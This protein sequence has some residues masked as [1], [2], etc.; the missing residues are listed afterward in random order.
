MTKGLGAQ[1]APFLEHTLSQPSASQAFDFLGGS[2]L[3]E[4]HAALEEGMPGES[5]CCWG[6]PRILKEA[7]VTTHAA[8]QQAEGSWEPLVQPVSGG[9]ARRPHI[10]DQPCRA[11]T[12]TRP[13]LCLRPSPCR[14]A[15]VFSAGVPAHF[16]SNFQAAMRFIEALEGYCT[17][18]AQVWRAGRAGGCCRGRVAGAGAC[19]LQDMT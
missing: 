1:C 6:C 5:T 17:Q 3:A 7:D 16:H 9:P 18:Q 15:G 4:V 13:P 8:Q 12:P 10:T 11:P 19:L 14:H 2:L